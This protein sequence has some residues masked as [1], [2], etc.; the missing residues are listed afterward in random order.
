MEELDIELDIILAKTSTVQRCLTRI[1]YITR[2]RLPETLDEL[3]RQ[4]IFILNLQRATQAVIDIA[5]HIVS[6]KNL[7]MPQT[8]KDSF[9]LLRM[10]AGLDKTLSKHM[11]GMVGF[12]NIAVHAYQEISVDV[13]KA[14]LT[15]QLD[16]LE[17]FCGYALKS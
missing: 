9:R 2:G 4:D 11:E 6:E 17:A 7:G 5:A 10:H 15:T 16:D 1:D 14:I 8:L 13:L 3:D 12:R